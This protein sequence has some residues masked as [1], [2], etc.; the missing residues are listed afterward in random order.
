MIE[1]NMSTTVEQLHMYV[2]TV[3]PVEG[4][5]ALVTGFPPKPLSDPMATIQSAGLS[6]AQ[7]TQRTQ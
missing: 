2:M 3:A 7:I 4:N 6:K 5:Y 1:V